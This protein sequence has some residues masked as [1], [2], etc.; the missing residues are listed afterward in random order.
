VRLQDEG[1]LH[2]SDAGS[3]Y[4]KIAV[5]QREAKP[6]QEAELRKT[7][8]TEITIETD[9]LLVVAT[10][11]VSVMSWCPACGHRTN[12]VTVDEAA[13]LGCVS[14][15]TIYQW[16]ESERLHFA[17]TS[18]GRLLICSDSITA[19]ATGSIQLERT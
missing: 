15:R 13:G 6:F 12:M 7:K 5:P 2:L 17:E 8:R 19:A 18:E 9:R 16:V 14:S 11:R 4:N 1:C 3:L 10:R